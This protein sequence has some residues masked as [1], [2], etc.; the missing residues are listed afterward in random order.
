MEKSY[1]DKFKFVRIPV[2]TVVVVPSNVTLVLPRTA[3]KAQSPRRMFILAVDGD[4]DESMHLSLPGPSL[5]MVPSKHPP[6][7]FASS[8][9]GFLSKAAHVAVFLFKQFTVFDSAVPIF[10]NC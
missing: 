5:P 8:A 3:N 10:T 1:N 9:Q 6:Q 7:V 4:G 2:E